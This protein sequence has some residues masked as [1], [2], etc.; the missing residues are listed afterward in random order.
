MNLFVI[1]LTKSL[2]FLF[3]FLFLCLHDLPYFSKFDKLINCLKGDPGIISHLLIENHFVH[4]VTRHWSHYVFLLFV[5]PYSI[6]FLQLSLVQLVKQ[7]KWTRLVILL[8]LLSLL[9]LLGFT[10]Q[11]NLFF[12]FWLLLVVLGLDVEVIGVPKVLSQIFRLLRLG[13]EEP[14]N[15]IFGSEELQFVSGFDCKASQQFRVSKRTH[16]NLTILNVDILKP[17]LST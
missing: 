17:N 6:V 10:N 11:Q 8:F 13:C 5:V 9:L 3:F 1:I 2:F 16:I 14:I 15:V 12:F 7:S 4:I